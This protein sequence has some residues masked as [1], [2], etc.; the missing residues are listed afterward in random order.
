MA[1]AFRAGDDVVPLIAGEFP[2]PDPEPEDPLMAGEPTA[3][4]GAPGGAFLWG[5]GM[6]RSPR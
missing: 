1:F 2:F 4:A 5:W 6:S 3:A